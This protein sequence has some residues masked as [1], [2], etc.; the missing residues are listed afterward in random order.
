[1]ISFRYSKFTPRGRKKMSYL[2]GIGVDPPT[3]GYLNA[4]VFAVSRNT[5][6]A[7]AN[8]AFQFFANNVGSFA[9]SRSK[10]LERRRWR[11]PPATFA[12]VEF[13]DAFSLSGH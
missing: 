10:R 2:A 9:V 7:I 12:Q 6:S 4:G 1:M 8:E 3:M 13:S 11:P 5:W